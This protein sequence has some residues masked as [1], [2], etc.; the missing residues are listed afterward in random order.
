MKDYSSLHLTRDLPPLVEAPD[1]PGEGGPHHE[2][3]AAEPGGATRA[4][5]RSADRPG[6]LPGGDRRRT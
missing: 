6:D 2:R 3:R 1:L 4:A 5:P